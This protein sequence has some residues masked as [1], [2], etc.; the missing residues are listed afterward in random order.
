MIVQR[1]FIGEEHEKAT[2]SGSLYKY[3]KEYVGKRYPSGVREVDWDVI[4]VSTIIA[5][6]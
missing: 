1:K 2:I 5:S 4:L 3:F 6:T